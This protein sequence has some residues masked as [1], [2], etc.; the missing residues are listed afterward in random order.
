MKTNNFYWTFQQESSWLELLV[1]IHGMVTEYKAHPMNS[2]V[3]L[4][5][6]LKI[7]TNLNTLSLLMVNDK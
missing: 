5:T 7:G 1:C 6:W 3:F 2:W 4:G